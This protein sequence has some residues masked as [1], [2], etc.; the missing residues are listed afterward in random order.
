MKEKIVISVSGT[1]RIINC[2][3][4]LYFEAV[5]GRICVHFVYEGKERMLEFEG[6]LKEI[7]ER[8]TDK[9]F[10]RIH[11]S[12]IVALDKIIEVNS[13]FVIIKGREK[14]QLPIGRVY[15]ERLEKALKMKGFN[16]LGR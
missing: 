8:L 9:G 10:V 4:V 6:S 2:D 11:K 3:D 5:S 15:E 12:C 13:G 7:E 1:K 16:H 14:R